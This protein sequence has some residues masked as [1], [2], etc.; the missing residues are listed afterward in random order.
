MVATLESAGVRRPARQCILSRRGPVGGV[1]RIR[2]IAWAED[3]ECAR[4][5]GGDKTSARGR[6]FVGHPVDV[7]GER[8]H[9]RADYILRAG[10]NHGRDHD[11]LRAARRAG[12]VGGRGGALH[13]A[14]RGRADMA[15]GSAIDPALGH[16]VH[17]A[18]D[19][20]DVVL[21]ANGARRDGCEGE[22]QRFGGL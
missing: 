16:S 6:A 21:R 10:R 14:R 18:R 11:I 7:P 15:A 5:A 17:P 8:D 20:A 22:P 19:R 12:G 9:A 13:R 2:R 1:R 3:C 4:P